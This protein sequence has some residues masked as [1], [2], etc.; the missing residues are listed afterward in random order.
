VRVPPTSTIKFGA[1][2]VG[3]AFTRSDR[4]LTQ[5]RSSIIPWSTFLE[6]TVPMHGSTFIEIVC[7]LDLD[8]V[9]LKMLDIEESHSRMIISYPVCLNER[10]RELS[11]DHEERKFNTIRSHSPVRNLPLIVT[12][13]ASVRDILLVVGIRIVLLSQTPRAALRHGSI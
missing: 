9:T 11:V 1:E 2:A 5:T 8:P 12:S 7:N 6:E 3:E 4:T 10:S 13:H